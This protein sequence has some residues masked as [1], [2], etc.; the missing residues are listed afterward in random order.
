MSFLVT[1]GSLWTV[2]RGCEAK[3]KTYYIVK[4]GR[5]ELVKVRNDLKAEHHSRNIVKYKENSCIGTGAGEGYAI[6]VLA[7]HLGRFHQSEEAITQVGSDWIS[8]A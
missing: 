3:S 2:L 5:R 1:S 6:H 4:L 7:S 8:K